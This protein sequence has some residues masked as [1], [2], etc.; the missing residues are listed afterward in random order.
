MTQAIVQ[1][2]SELAQSAAPDLPEES[3]VESDSPA[4]SPPER[5]ITL[6]QQIEQWQ[7]LLEKLGVEVTD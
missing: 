5:V 6:P 7:Q 1:A 3:T 4:S 2:E